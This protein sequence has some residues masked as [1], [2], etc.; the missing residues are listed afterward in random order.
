MNFNNDPRTTLADV[1]RLFELAEES[2][3]RTIG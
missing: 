1:H 3:R 2:L